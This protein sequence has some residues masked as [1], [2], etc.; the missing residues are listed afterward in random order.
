M[1]DRSHMAGIVKIEEAL[2]EVTQKATTRVVEE[3]H[4]D[5]IC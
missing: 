1:A 2:S 3:E 4:R 5:F